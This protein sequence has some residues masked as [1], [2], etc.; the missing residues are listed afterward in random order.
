MDGD[1]HTQCKGVSLKG[2]MYWIAKSEKNEYFILSFDYS[3]ETF[4]NICVCLRLPDTGGLG[5]FNGDRL[6]L[7]LQDIQFGDQEVSTDIAVWVT[8]KLSDEIV[9]FTKCFNVTSPHLPLL[10]DHSDQPR[11][12]IYLDPW[13]KKIFGFF[14]T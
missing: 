7:L 6:F 1:V 13:T 11:P 8:N 10:Q 14:L 5:S 9:S 2:N 12:N 4:K 3:I